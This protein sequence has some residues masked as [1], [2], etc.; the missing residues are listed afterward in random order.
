MSEGI[1]WRINRE[2]HFPNS[3]AGHVMPYRIDAIQG[4][5]DLGTV[6]T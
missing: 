5:R 2:V 6:H 1:R 3:E 4:A